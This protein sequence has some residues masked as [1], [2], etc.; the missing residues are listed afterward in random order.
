MDDAGDNADV[1]CPRAV[2][3][4]KAVDEAKWMKIRSITRK[5]TAE[6][7]LLHNVVARAHCYK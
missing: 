5:C 4:V 6:S 7:A 1:S 2:C 3:N